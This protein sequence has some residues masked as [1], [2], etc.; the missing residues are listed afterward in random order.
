MKKLLFPTLVFVIV[1]SCVTSVRA[2]S[3]DAVIYWNGVAAAA[4]AAATSP[5]PPGTPLPVPP[6]RPGQVGGLD[7]A[8]VHVAM[9]DAIQAFDQRFEQYAGDF[10]EVSGSRQAA[11]AA[12]AH[13][14][15]MDLYAAYPWVTAMVDATYTQYLNDNGLVGDPGIAAG[16]QAAT[17]IITLRIN[18]GRFASVPPFTG[19]TAPGEWRPTE[20][21]NLPPGTS[22]PTPPGPPPSFAPMAIPW[23]GNV[24]PFTIISPSQF[25]ASPPPALTSPEYKRAY[26]EVKALGLLTSALRTAEQTDVGYFYAD[27]FILLLN[28]LV[29]AI[30]AQHLDD[31]GDAARLFALVYLAEADSGIT[32]WDSKKYYDFWRPLT[33]IRDGNND[34]NPETVG[35]PDWKPLINTPNYPGYTSGANNVTAAAVKMLSLFFRGDKMTFTVHSNYPLAVQKNRTYTHFSDL[36]QDVV[37]VRIWQGIHFR[38]DDEAAR[39]QGR[40]VAKW[41]YQHFLRP[42]HGENDS[43]ANLDDETTENDR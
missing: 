17:N 39:R 6:P 4:L 30:A 1:W 26:D 22:P 16:Q 23:L 42:V 19:G 21:F 18:D 35:D 36:A 31:L 25:R 33:A 40:D 13:D 20:S 7:F 12:A 11:V 8:M 5:A 43:L 2:A 3:V 15:L 29:S 14:V 37:D 10:I 34:T 28:R 9:H 32:A 41:A 27:N 24:V 38:F